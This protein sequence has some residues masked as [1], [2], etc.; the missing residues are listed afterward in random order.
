MLYLLGFICYHYFKYIHKCTVYI[1]LDEDETRYWGPNAPQILKCTPTKQLESL[2]NPS[3]KTFI[4][5]LLNALIAEQPN[6][7]AKDSKYLFLFL[8]T[9]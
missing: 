9:S 2:V 5:D 1:V 6:K 7:N 4:W 8:I 3:I